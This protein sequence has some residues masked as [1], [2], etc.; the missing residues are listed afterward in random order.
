MRNLLKNLTIFILI[1]L[2]FAA[3][4]SS[5]A[6]QQPKPENISLSQLAEKIKT[7]QIKEI[8]IDSEE[9]KNK[10]GKNVRVSSIEITLEKI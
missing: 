8:K 9:F 7:G 1:L 2:L 10:E 3:V 6:A 5:F 4:F